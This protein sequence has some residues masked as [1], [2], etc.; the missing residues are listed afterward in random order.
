MT[1]QKPLNHWK[2]GVCV[3]I[4][5][6]IFQLKLAIL[7]YLERIF[8]YIF[9]Y[10]CERNIKRGKIHRIK[11]IKGIWF[12]NLSQAGGKNSLDAFC[13]LKVPWTQLGPGHLQGGCLASCGMGHPWS[14]EEAPG[15]LLTRVTT[16]PMR[17]QSKCFNM[18]AS[19]FRLDLE[20]G[21]VEPFKHIP[22]I[23]GAA[24]FSLLTPFC[25]VIT[26][27]TTGTRALAWL[28]SVCSSASCWWLRSIPDPCSLPA[29][30]AAYPRALLYPAAG[31][32]Y[33]S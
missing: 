7:V 24:K 33:L 16:W 19:L 25:W 3:C 6:C 28:A 31:P 10:I 11:E 12:S 17:K 9:I 32:N 29:V 14:I 5:V 8:N 13:E 20:E 2:M 23:R 30:T 1:W 27:A 15:L 18:F 26:M 22:K 4:W 21:R